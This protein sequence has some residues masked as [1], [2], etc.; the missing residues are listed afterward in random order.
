MQRAKPCAACNCGSGSHSTDLPA[1]TISCAAAPP[2]LPCSCGG[3]VL[4]LQRTSKHNF[5][6]WGLPGGNTDATDRDLLHT[7][8]RE[9]EEEMGASVP[10]YEVVAEVLTQRGKR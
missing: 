2:P 7:A 4:L 1:Q 3:E 8:S 6:T 5:G 9:A 10:A